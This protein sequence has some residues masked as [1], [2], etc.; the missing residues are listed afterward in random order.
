[1]GAT[2]L[3]R[4]ASPAAGYFA[5]VYHAKKGTEYMKNK[6]NLGKRVLSLFVAFVMC[7]SMLPGTALAIQW[8]KEH[9]YNSDCPRCANAEGDADHDLTTCEWWTKEPTSIGTHWDK[10]H[11]VRYCQCCGREWVA[12]TGC[13]DQGAI[14]AQHPE[15]PKLHRH[16]PKQIQAPTCTTP[17]KSGDVCAYCGDTI[18]EQEIPTIPHTANTSWDH[19][20]NTHWKNCTTEGCTAKLEEAIYFLFF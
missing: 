7:V 17:G 1:M 9:K 6:K 20:A 5:S 14:C 19:D 13:K 18:N 8:G 12:G 16:E 15:N 3:T 10:L 11:S 4:Y 2:A